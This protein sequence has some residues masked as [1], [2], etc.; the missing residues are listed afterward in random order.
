MCVTSLLS[1]LAPMETF[2]CKSRFCYFAVS[3]SWRLL[4][5][6]NR[7]PF[8]AVPLC[9]SCYSDRES[10]SFDHSTLASV[11]RL[12]ILVRRYRFTASVTTSTRLHSEHRMSAAAASTPTAPSTGS[13]PLPS[14]VPKSSNVSHIICSVVNRA[15]HP[16]LHP[17]FFFLLY[18]V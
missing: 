12:L 3:R 10:S 7:P 15:V 17:F 16:H 5:S 2:S 1:Q 18:V 6:P 4:F 14:A 8:R 13:A 11:T 9:F